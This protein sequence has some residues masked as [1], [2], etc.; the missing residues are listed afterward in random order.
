MQEKFISELK[1]KSISLLV[2]K[3]ILEAKPFVFEESDKYIEWKETLSELIQV[4][5]K[6]IIFTG[7]SSLGFSL[8]PNKNYKQY[9]DTSDI[10]LAIISELY[11]NL[12]WFEIRNIGTKYF[13]LT[14][15]QQNSISDHRTRLIYWGTIATDKL[16]P[17]FSFGKKWNNAIERM[18]KLHPTENRE[19]NFRIYKDFDSLRAYQADNLKKIQIK[20]FENE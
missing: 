18:S 19:I 20:L 14:K 9:D 4:D 3:W 12:S 11:F 17:I 6:A 13:D 1:S 10:D 16:L 2:S 15:K 7:S 8:N 5:S